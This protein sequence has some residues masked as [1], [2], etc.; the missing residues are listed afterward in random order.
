MALETVIENFKNRRA[1]LVK[2][3]AELGISIADQYG[4]KYGLDDFIERN[5]DN[6]RH[7]H[8]ISNPDGF[9]N[10]VAGQLQQA[11]DKLAAE[12]PRT[13]ED[14]LADMEWRPAPRQRPVEQERRTLPP[15]PEGMYRGN[16]MDS[17]RTHHPIVA[18]PPRPVAAPRKLGAEETVVDIPEDGPGLG[19][20]NAEYQALLAQ[21]R[22]PT[23]E[24]PSE[25]PLGSPLVSER[26]DPS[27]GAPSPLRPM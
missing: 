3:A 26:S 18:D 6:I 23:E 1:S 10:F 21:H 13:V 17:T 11:K 15:L 27:T 14:E 9:H 20:E 8:P 5:V 12:P 22:R 7:G 19:E 25:N 2:L 16:F 4:S 24:A